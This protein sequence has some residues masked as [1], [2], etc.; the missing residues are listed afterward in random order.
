MV[1]L[2]LCVGRLVGLTSEI[3]LYQV[4]SLLNLR[5]SLSQT[6]FCCATK[7]EPNKAGILKNKFGGT[8]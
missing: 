1:Q 5:S 6:F 8:R 2:A 3:M 4:S 7:I